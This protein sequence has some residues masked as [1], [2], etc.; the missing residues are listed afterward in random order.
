MPEISQNY[1]IT[2]LDKEALFTEATGAMEKIGGYIISEN[3]DPITN[4]KICKFGVKSFWTGNAIEISYSVNEQGELNV[5]GYIP[6]I[7]ISPLTKQMDSFINTL[8]TNLNQKY[9][10]NF[11]HPKLT[12]FLPPY[13]M[14]INELDKK[15]FYYGL[16]PIISIL[17][18]AAIDEIR[19]YA[20]PIFENFLKLLI[21][22]TP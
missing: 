21:K 9:Q 18:L 7:S 5:L 13:K 19:H 10:I 8:A 22:S 1:Q 14:K 3:I 12:V 16:I 17:I 2:G 4:N 15:I 11:K 20:L 6:Q